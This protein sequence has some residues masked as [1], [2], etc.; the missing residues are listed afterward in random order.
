MQNIT[1]LNPVDYVQRQVLKSVEEEISLAVE[2][3]LAQQCSCIYY[4]DLMNNIPKGFASKDSL[5]AWLN[6]KSSKNGVRE[7]II[8][9]YKKERPDHFEN[10]MWKPV[11]FPAFIK[12]A[13]EKLTDKQFVKSRSLAEMYKLSF[14]DR[15]WLAK[16]AAVMGIKLLEELYEQK[17]L[18]SVIAQTILK[19]NFLTRRLI[20][21]NASVYGRNLKNFGIT[22]IDNAEI[23]KNITEYY[24]EIAALATQEHSQHHELALLRK[25][26]PDIEKALALIPSHIQ[27]AMI[28]GEVTS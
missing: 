14:N 21:R 13:C 11:N 25:Y 7:G 19:I 8:T 2:V 1:L 16:A 12:F 20:E 22:D 18:R 3:Y 28:E 26:K 23:R 5:I 4:A 6:D 10:G 9:R 17:R 24:R 15:D 27:I